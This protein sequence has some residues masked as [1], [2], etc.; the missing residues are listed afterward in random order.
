MSFQSLI[1]HNGVTHQKSIPEPTITTSTTETKANQK[2]NIDTQIVVPEGNSVLETQV[3]ETPDSQTENSNTTEIQGTQDLST[4][5]L[6]QD[7]EN[8]FLSC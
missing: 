6:F 8:L 3:R 1:A 7:L 5:P 2:P 4:Q